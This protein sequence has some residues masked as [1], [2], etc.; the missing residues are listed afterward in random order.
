MLGNLVEF[1][2][3]FL[4]DRGRDPPVV[5]V[6]D[7]G[8]DSSEGHPQQVQPQLLVPDDEKLKMDATTRLAVAA[9]E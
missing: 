8:P 3:P 5:G 6:V 7:E 9:S 4:L 2:R 1:V